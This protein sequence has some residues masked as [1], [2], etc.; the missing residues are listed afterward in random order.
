MTLDTLR[1]SYAEK[2][3]D[4]AG[5]RLEALTDAFATVPR[6]RF[7]D[8]GPWQIMQPPPPSPAPAAAQLDAMMAAFGGGP[9]PGAPRFDLRALYQTTPDARVEHL[10]DDVLVAIDPARQLNNGQPSAHARWMDAAAPRPGEAVLHVGCGTGYFT[11]ILA[12]LVG[13]TGRVV[14]VELDPGLAARA[15]ACLAPWPQV[16]V[17][18]GDAGRPDG[19]FDVIYVNAGAT[20]ARKEWLAALAEGGRLLLPLTVHLPMFPPEHGIGF[21]V[22]AERRGA[23]WP[24][25]IVSPVGIF[26]CAGARDPAAE[27]Q[28]RRFLR[29]GAAADLHA[30]CSDGHVRGEHCLVHVDGFCL[31]S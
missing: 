15:R 4:T 10:Y 22:C 23:R 5:V 21:V 12:E 16:R 25:R 2:I 6:E 30:L 9:P 7:L 13:G 18:A 27:A 3:R 26:D 1:R 17:E 14:A 8:P 11:A 24:V 29:P 19:P 20:H 31:Q 28:L